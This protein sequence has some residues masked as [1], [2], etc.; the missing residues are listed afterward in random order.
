MDSSPLRSRK[1]PALLVALVPYLFVI[2]DYLLDARFPV[3][4]SYYFH[5]P[6]Y[7]YIGDSLGATWSFPEWLPIGGGIRPG[8]LQISLLY[9]LPHRL[10]GYALLAWAPLSPIVAY[11]LQYAFGV[12]LMGAGWWLFLERWTGSM[13]AASFGT[14]ALVM[15]GTGVTVHQEQVL[16][17]SYL[18]PW[19]LLAV[20]HLQTD[21]RLLYALALMFGLA[22]T[23]H[24]PHILLISFVVF[25]LVMLLFH[26]GPS[27][28]NARACVGPQFVLSLFLFF[29]AAAPALYILAHLGEFESPL[30][31]SQDAPLQAHSFDAYL[32]L[33]IEANLGSSAFAAELPHYLM[34]G[35]PSDRPDLASY[36]VGRVTLLMALAAL[37]LSPLRALPVVIMLGFFVLLTLGIR[38]PVPLVE[39][40]FAL[41]P[42]IVGLFRQ[43]FHFFPMIN[44]CLTAL[45]A[46]GLAAAISRFD[47]ILGRAGPAVLVLL[48]AVH[49][50]ELTAYGGAYL[51]EWSRARSEQGALLIRAAQGEAPSWGIASDRTLLQY[52]NRV[53][54][55]ACCGWALPDSPVV[56]T[57]VRSVT[58]G[59]S[60]Q[61]AALQAMS[62]QTRRVAVVDAPSSLLTPVARDAG[63]EVD[64]ELGKLRYGYDGVEI[65][66]SVNRAAILVL[67]IN[68]DLGLEARIDGE[69]IALWRVN[70]ALTG[71]LLPQ[72]VSRVE[73]RVVPDLY[74][75]IAL[76]QILCVTALFALLGAAAF[77]GK[78]R[79]SR[80]RRA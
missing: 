35:F 51:A 56:T 6:V 36:F 67:P 64:A 3:Q 48:F 53:R 50:V 7:E 15:G 80:A 14:M 20:R 46:L 11:N 31:T 70:A 60:A 12:L 78:R 65:D 54:A 74:R 4:D 69:P 76:S 17:T 66:V 16:G 24:F 9:F 25:V 43:W 44:F 62:N 40:L 8:V 58:G 52:D 41:A 13:L 10:L 1:T 63:G 28:R 39:T 45:A 59:A 38:A 18:V 49:L 33:S 32:A 34:P 47:G 23:L 77:R 29:I 2:W 55:N 75:W 19:F 27:L 42:E 21:R 73:I 72:G 22:A 5:F 57:V 61:L 30:R 68:Y 26:F 79:A 71:L 37:L